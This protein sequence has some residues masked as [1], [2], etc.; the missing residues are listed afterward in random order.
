MGNNVIKRLWNKNALTNIEDLRGMTFQA[1][2]AGHT[3]EIRGVDGDGNAIALSGTPAGVMLRPDNTDVALTCAVSEG[4]VT[5]TLPAE[6]YDVPGRFGL[7]VYLTS[8]GQKT[9]IYAAIGSVSRT[10]SGN[11]SPATTASVV[12]LINAIEDAIEQIPASDTNLKAALAPTY[13]TSAVYPVGG[14][15]WQEGELY[16][17]IVPI[18]IG[19][20]WNP[21][22]WTK[23]K[24]ASDVYDLKSALEFKTDSL[25][26]RTNLLHSLVDYGYA[27]AE[28][29]ANPSASAAKDRLGI[30]RNGTQ[31]IINLASSASSVLRVKVSGELSVA[32]SNAMTDAWS[33]G[34][35]LIEGHKYRATLMFESGTVTGDNAI[36]LSIYETG[37]HV[38]IGNVI[39]SGNPFVREFTA[40]ST[41]INIAIYIPSG[42]TFTNAKYQVIL[43]D[44]ADERVI[45]LVDE[46]LSVYGDAADAKVTGQ[47]KNATIGY[48]DYLM[49]GTGLLP[50]LW[51]Q[52]NVSTSGVVELKHNSKSVVTDYIPIQ[53]S[54]KIIYEKSEGINAVRICEY[55]ATKTFLR[56]NPLRSANTSYTVGN[57]TSFVVL[58]YL[59][60]GDDVITPEYAAEHFYATV[61]TVD[62]T[63]ECP[64]G[65]HTMPKSDGVLNCIKRARQMTDIQ[66]SVASDIDRVCIVSGKSYDS[67]KIYYQNEFVA[68]RKYT[69][70]PYSEQNLLGTRKGITQFITSAANPNGKEC[71]D[72][73]YSGDHNVASFFGAVC[74][75]LVSY[76]LHAPM[77]TSPYYSNMV[78]LTKQYDLYSDGSYHSI[79][80]IE[81]CDVLWEHGHAAII[82]DIIR[83]SLN[84]V[85]FV[86]VSEATKFGSYVK[87]TSNGDYG[88]KCRRKIWAKDDF[89]NWFSS[90]GVYRYSDDLLAAIPYTPCPYVP[91][92]D[93]PSYV[94]QAILPCVPE[95]GT[96]SLY[97]VSNASQRSVTILISDNSY[98]YLRIKQNGENYDLVAIT[99]ASSVVVNC[100]AN[101]EAIYEAYLCNISNG[102]ETSASVSCEWLEIKPTSVPT[103]HDNGDGSY[104]FS[105]QRDLDVAYPV[106][107][108][109]NTTNANSGDY[110]PILNYSKTQ[111]G[112]KFKYTFTTTP[113]ESVES[114]NT[115]AVFF[116]YG[117]Y[118][119]ATTSSLT[120]TIV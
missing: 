15:A 39:P 80:D 49:R 59:S 23:A 85:T 94:E 6:C 105:V 34:L 77:L 48:A 9:A 46:T 64:L 26:D 120:P 98:D 47:A 18:T 91:M 104:T 109:Y 33:T 113:P 38:S 10:S 35:S 40:T 57:D 96:K 65:L 72:S 75:T 102:E 25:S 61:S 115:F 37:T 8:D 24:L 1:E 110:S 108:L 16:K 21:S 29:V 51:Y 114:I 55:D 67:P 28:K 27:D 116:D 56:Y 90:F 69:G 78:G 30:K 19:E 92:E 119:M 117:E 89:L 97:F 95:E 13:S 112:G 73:Q 74:V 43:C 71:T 54:T 93:E 87:D 42:K 32:S 11:V 118:G 20:T 2:E 79:E 7:T 14:Y 41:A 44:I 62:K 88:G 22:H 45:P 100:E 83:D 3:F 52:G 58:C 4:V 36:E 50:L 31:C 111:S 81:L 86:E 5:A 70:L 82:T 66:W 107:V 103:I 106:A 53:N 63:I 99:N 68:G 101:K 12:D 60:A 84:H 17:C 76:A